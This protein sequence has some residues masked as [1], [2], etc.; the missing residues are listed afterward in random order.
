MV[1]MILMQPGGPGSAIAAL[2]GPV[3]YDRGLE[4]QYNCPIC[5]K[6]YHHPIIFD[7]CGHV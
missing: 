1:I 6:V 4:M 5:L 2:A 7:S 3:G